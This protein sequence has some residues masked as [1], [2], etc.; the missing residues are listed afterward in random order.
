[1]PIPT[2]ENSRGYKCGDFTD[3]NGV[4]CSIQK[5]SSLNEPLLWLG[6]NKV[7]PKIRAME[8][9]Q[10]GIE[11]E[12]RNGWINVPIPNAALIGGRMHL[13]RETVKELLPLLQRFAETGEI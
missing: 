10:Y 1:M 11:T 2:K 3:Y 7:H 4:A 5:S 13:D 8:A 12:E 6:V 9:S